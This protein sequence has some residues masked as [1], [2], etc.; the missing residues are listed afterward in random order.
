M[1]PMLAHVF[2]DKRWVGGPCWL[3]PKF[4]GVRAL[5]QSGCFQSRDELPWPKDFLKHLSEPLQAMFPDER[6]I[7][8]G[9][10]YVH[11]WKLQRINQAVAVNATVRGTTADTLEVSYYVFDAVSFNRPFIV[12]FNEVQQTIVQLQHPKIH[13][14]TTVA[15]PDRQWVEKF[16]AETISVGFEGIMYR[17]GLCPYTVPKQ[18]KENEK[19]FLSDKNNRVWHLLKRKSWMDEEFFCIGLEEGEGKRAGMVGAFVCVLDH[20]TPTPKTFCV[21]SGLTDTEAKHYFDNPPIGRK[22]KVKFLTYTE[23]GIPFNPTVEA[24]L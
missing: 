10:L 16:Y 24:V 2:E 15:P 19:G 3:Q 7:L 18:P 13:A 17:V 14:A 8:D 1:R 23:D 22:I 21:G 11:G 9:E 4:N 20:L 5:Y 6:T 12:R